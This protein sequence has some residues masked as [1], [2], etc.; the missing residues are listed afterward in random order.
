VKVK[1]ITVEELKLLK[2]EEYNLID[3][4]EEWERVENGFIP[5]AE[6]IPMDEILSVQ[7]MLV[8]SDCKV[9]FYCRSGR[10][11]SAVNLH[12]T[13]FY[14]AENTYNLEGG[15]NEWELINNKENG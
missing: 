5:L 1:T 13:H 12:L 9:I 4:R 7:D 8:K 2:P 10:R 14:N 15:F 11:S 6:H 3:I